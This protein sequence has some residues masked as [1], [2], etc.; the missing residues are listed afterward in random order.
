MDGDQV[1]N[2]LLAAGGQVVTSGPH[3]GRTIA[4]VAASGPSVVDSL[5][6]ARGGSDPT[7]K[8]LRQYCRIQKELGTLTDLVNMMPP[9]AGSSPAVVPVAAVGC[10]TLVSRPALPRVQ[11]GQLPLTLAI[12]PGQAG[13]TDRV[14]QPLG[15]E[16]MG[17]WLTALLQTRVWAGLLALLTLAVP[18]LVISVGLRL[19]SRFATTLVGAMSDAASQTATEATF[20]IETAA[21]ELLDVNVTVATHEVVEIEARTPRWAVALLGFVAARLWN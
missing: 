7:L 15:R 5:L 13:P 20:L 2:T 18:R 1:L 21:S 19:A 11:Q 9:L 14:E 10:G 6:R 12:V 16:R 8:L 3:R 4:Q 17:L